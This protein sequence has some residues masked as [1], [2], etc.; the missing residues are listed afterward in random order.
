MTKYV[1]ICIDHSLDLDENDV[2]PVCEALSQIEVFDWL[3]RT[4]PFL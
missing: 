4:F 2:C 3:S 1:Y